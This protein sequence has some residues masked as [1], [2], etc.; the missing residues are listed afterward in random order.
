MSDPVSARERVHIKICRDDQCMREYS[1]PGNRCR[2][3][4][5]LLGEV[6]EQALH[7][8]GGRVLDLHMDAVLKNGAEVGQGLILAAKEIQPYRRQPNGSL[9]RASDG[10]PVPRF[11]GDGRG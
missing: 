10:S 7:H 2:D 6:E 1:M 4:D 11:P 8:A 3:L 9:V 5:R